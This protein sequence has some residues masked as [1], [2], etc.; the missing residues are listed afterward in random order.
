MR[1]AGKH[2]TIPTR[3]SSSALPNRL[4]AVLTNNILPLAEKKYLPEY[5]S[6]GFTKQEMVDDII[7]NISID[8]PELLDDK[9][10]FTLCVEKAL[11][12]I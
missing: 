11:D 12:K 7:K 6:F 9:N 8:S 2:A 4:A 10:N 5:T 3:K 1:L